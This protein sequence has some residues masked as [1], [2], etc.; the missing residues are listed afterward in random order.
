MSYQLLKEDI[1][2]YQCFLKA[3]GY[4][5]AKL[6]GK[7]GPKTDAADA[8][9]LEQSN[10]IGTEYGFFDAR[11]ISGTRTYAEQNTLYRKGRYGSTEN[12][13]TTILELPGILAYSKTA[14]TLPTIK[15]TNNWP[16]W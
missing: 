11:I 3:N 15:S 10:R 7:W 16:H 14:N 9:F 12:K 5:T 13:V 2:F 8:A 4:Y 1:L 6:D